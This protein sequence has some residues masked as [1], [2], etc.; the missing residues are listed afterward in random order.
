MLFAKTLV[1]IIL[2]TD[3]FWKVKKNQLRMEHEEIVAW[4][5]RFSEFYDDAAKFFG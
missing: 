5:E 4:K 2:R 3:I 1:H